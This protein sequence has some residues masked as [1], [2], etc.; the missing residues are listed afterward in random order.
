MT[1]ARSVHYT[2]KQAEAV[3]YLALQALR[4][5]RW[6]PDWS[7]ALDAAIREGTPGYH[8][9]FAPFATD[10][11]GPSGTIEVEGFGQQFFIGEHLYDQK[12]PSWDFDA[13]FTKPLSDTKDGRRP[14]GRTSGSFFL[15]PPLPAPGADGRDEP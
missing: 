11:D 1:G 7:A 4:R 9:G 2:P 8:H 10:Y 6:E 15:L 12:P 3:S 5:D 14:A 13:G